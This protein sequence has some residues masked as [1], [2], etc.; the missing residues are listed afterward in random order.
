MKTATKKK[1]P[2]PKES[3][4]QKAGIEALRDIGIEVHRRNVIAVR[5]TYKGKSRMVRSGEAG[6]ADLYGWLKSG[7]HF[8]A[9]TK[10]PGE[11]PRLNQ[12]EWLR[13]ANIDTG[14]A[15]WYSDVSI[16]VAIIR[17]LMDGGRIVYLDGESKY[18]NPVK[19]G[20]GKVVGP[21]YLFEVDMPV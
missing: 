13:R 18:P 11:T 8:E 16:L 21:S 20:K 7:L 17:S 1:P 2:K 12:I 14:A 9:E 5:G 15:F 19:G 6:Q 10:R 3:E 4:V